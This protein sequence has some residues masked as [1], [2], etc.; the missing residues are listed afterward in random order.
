MQT[1]YIFWKDGTYTLLK[2]KNAHRMSTTYIY[3]IE[4]MTFSQFDIVENY[5]NNEELYIFIEKD[6]V[7]WIVKMTRNEV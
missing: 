3:E 2:G 7:K 4:H 6:T 1:V 5:S